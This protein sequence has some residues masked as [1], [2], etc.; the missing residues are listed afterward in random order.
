LNG[1]YYARYYERLKMEKFTGSHD[2]MDFRLGHDVNVRSYQTSRFTLTDERRRSCDYC[3]G[4][5]HVHSLE[6]EPSE[7]LDDP[8]HH[9][10]IIQH[11][12]KSNEE[13]DGGELSQSAREKPPFTI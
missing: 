1:F 2:K 4:A 7:M 13:N 3:L 6:K 12:D 8:L 5:G 9:T 10:E 11:L